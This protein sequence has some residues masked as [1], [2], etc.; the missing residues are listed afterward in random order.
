MGADPA[1]GP[2]PLLVF[3]GPYSNLRALAALRARAGELGIPAA[4]CICTGDVVAYCA[5][6]EETTAA[7]CDW[8]A[9]VAA[10]NCEQ[11]LAAAAEDCACGF[12]E[13]TECDLLAKGWYPFA[14][15]RVSR[16]SRA[17]MA[18]LPGTLTFTLAGLKFRVI[19]G[20]VDVINRFVFASERQVLAEELERSGVDVIV[21]GHAGV[22]FIEKVGKAV[23]FNPGVIGMPANDGTADVWYGL[24][25]VEDGG[26]VLSTHRLAY[27]HIG[28]AAAMRRAGHA[29]GYARTLVTG[30][31]PSLDVLPP[32]ERA[33]TGKRL[34]Q[35]TLRVPAAALV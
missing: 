18:G 7:I 23:W 1:I 3:G 14:N 21:A 17:W 11:Q 26:L 33:A 5:E 35:R 20:G 15:A 8:G 13:G 24:V 31:W 6:P 27:D 12:E 32:P 16:E 25:R 22:P 29:D 28:A 34:R 30:L 19:H 10:G 2:L 9:R 4:S